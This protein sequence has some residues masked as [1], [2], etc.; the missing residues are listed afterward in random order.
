MKEGIIFEIEFSR[1]DK[2]FFHRVMEETS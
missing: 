1:F 2:Y